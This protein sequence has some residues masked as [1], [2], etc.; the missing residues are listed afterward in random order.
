M[1]NLNESDP[2]LIEKLKNFHNRTKENQEYVKNYSWPH[3]I[4]NATVKDMYKLMLLYEDMV[5]KV[6]I[7]TN[8]Y[9]YFTKDHK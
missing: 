1:K 5:M 3:A 9:N 2:N 4:S 8:R 6:Q 7:K